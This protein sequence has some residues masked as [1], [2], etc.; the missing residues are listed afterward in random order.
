VYR[1]V[2]IQ[3]C[4]Y[5]KVEIARNLGVDAERVERFVKFYIDLAR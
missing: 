2:T 4:I 1:P 5:F 3:P